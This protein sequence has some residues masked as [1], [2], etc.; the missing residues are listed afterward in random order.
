MNHRVFTMMGFALALHGSVGCG[1]DGSALQG[2]YTIDA[3]TENL[4]GCDAE[5]DSILEVQSD[6][7]LYLKEE[8]FF[9]TEF[10]NGVL[11]DDVA[12]CAEQAAEDTIYLDRFTFEDGNDD[13]GY[14]AGYCSGFCDDETGLCEGDYVEDVLTAEGDGVV[15]FETRRT[16]VSGMFS[17]GDGFCDDELARAAAEDAT[18]ASLEVITATFD[19]GL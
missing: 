11:C 19:S 2:I 18:C 12:Q 1:D 10:L 17:D 6:T 5:G 14:R 13:D 3:W 8:S 16:P 15:R 7:A 4:A 9:G